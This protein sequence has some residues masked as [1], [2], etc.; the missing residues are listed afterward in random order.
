MGGQAGVGGIVG[1]EPHSMNGYPDEPGGSNMRCR[2][3][4]V[5]TPARH[6]HEVPMHSL[7]LPRPHANGQKLS[8]AEHAGST[9][10][11]MLAAS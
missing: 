4:P 2:A 3:V 10:S 7:P 11:F 6:G 5:R 8:S 9:L 1:L